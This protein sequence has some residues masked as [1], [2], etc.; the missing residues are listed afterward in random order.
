[1]EQLNTNGYL[2]IY[3]GCMFAGKSSEII[4]EL[5]RRL[6]IKQKVLG[7]NY[8]EDKRYT[9]ED[10][11]VNHNLEKIHCIKVK[12][13]KDIP[14]SD[15]LVNDF[16]FIDEAQFFD[17]L[18]EYVLKW[19]DEYKKTVYVF[20]LDGDF[21]R[22][23]FGKIIDLIPHCNDIVKLKALCSLCKDGTDAL[24]THRITHENNQVVIGFDNY[25]PL[26]RKHYN[27]IN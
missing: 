19:V 6:I 21:K 17:D 7:I 16:I 3:I 23:Q 2:K 18:I 5:R 8:A 22:Q 4:K 1:M 26:C 27:D 12:N 11:I 15:I 20:G 9:D 25:I 10:Y 13:L 14:E 24:F